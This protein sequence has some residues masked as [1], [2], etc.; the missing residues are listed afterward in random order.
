MS[1]LYFFEFC[2]GIKFYQSLEEIVGNKIKASRS[3]SLHGIITVGTTGW[4]DAQ[5]GCSRGPSL[6]HLQLFAKPPHTRAAG[7]TGSNL[8]KINQGTIFALR[9]GAY[10]RVSVVSADLSA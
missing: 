6:L 5:N 8:G 2:F 1:K 9:L 4:A 3:L 7:K 10:M